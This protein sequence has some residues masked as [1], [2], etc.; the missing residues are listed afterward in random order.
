MEQHLA[1]VVAAL[2]AG[3][4]PEATAGE[5][6]ARL[7]REGAGLGEAMEALRRVAGNAGETGDAGSPGR[8]PGGGPSF[9]M[10]QALAVGWAE[11]AL[12]HARSRS[13]QDPLTGLAGPAHLAARLEEIYREGDLLGRPASRTHALVVLDMP[14]TMTTRAAAGRSRLGE[15]LGVLE[16]ADRVRRVFPGEETLCR[17]APG[18]LLVL[19]RRT[20]E[21]GRDVARVLALVDTLGRGP[22]RAVVEDLPGTVEGADALV[23][24]LS[25]TQQG[26]RLAPG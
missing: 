19:A 12:G 22:F 25:A 1:C 10:L 20:A 17:A 26:C 2:A 18:R 4:D 9:R 6:G 11:E 3:G 16:A 21:L 7:A 15:A 8:S 5:A 14:R 13:C 23:A 24:R